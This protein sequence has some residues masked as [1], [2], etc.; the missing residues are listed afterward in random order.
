MARII[1][2][3][4]F[5]AG[6]LFAEPH[7]GNIK[8]LTSGGQNAEAYWA[9]DGKRLIFQ[10]TRGDMKCSGKSKASAAKHHASVF[11]HEHRVGAG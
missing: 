2:A 9:P 1:F 10:S 11:V 5:A 6:S 3:A 7:L 4:L 8:Q